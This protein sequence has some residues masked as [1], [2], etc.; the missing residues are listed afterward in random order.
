MIR[1]GT[2]D[3]AKNAFLRCWTR[4][5][6]VVKALGQGL[7]LALNNFRV[8]TD[9]VNKDWLIEKP[10][11]APDYWTCT[12][13][14]SDEDYCVSLAAMTAQLSSASCVEAPRCG[15]RIILSLSITLSLGKSLT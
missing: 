1:Y 13:W 9:D 10:A 15:I 7:S 3:E 2:E 12:D 5:E 8:R 14:P 11:C 4:K 6:A